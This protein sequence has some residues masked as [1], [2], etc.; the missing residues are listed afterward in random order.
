[1]RRASALRLRTPYC[2]ILI[3]RHRETL[4]INVYTILY[5]R[6]CMFVCMYVFTYCKWVCK[7]M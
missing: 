6:V 2:A 5:I 4:H 1:M 3:S 7:M